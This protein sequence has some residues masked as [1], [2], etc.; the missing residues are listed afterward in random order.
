MSTGKIKFW[1]NTKKFGFIIESETK[2][3]IFVHISGLK[4]REFVPQQDD[5]VTFETEN[6]KKGLNAVEVE[7]AD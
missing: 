6:G 2:E 3:E 4:D 5:E 7:L 1:N